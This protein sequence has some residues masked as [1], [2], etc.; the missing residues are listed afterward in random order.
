[1]SAA[2]KGP[3]GS[4]DLGS[5][6]VGVG[7][8]PANQLIVNDTEVS[9]LHAQI[10]PQGQGHIVIDLGSSNGT[11]VNGQRL[12]P[13]TPHRLNAGDTVRFGD[14]VFSYIIGTSPH[15][16][17]KVVPP[18]SKPNIEGIQPQQTPVNP[19]PPKKETPGWIILVGGL[20]SLATIFGVIWGVYTYVH[21]GGPSIPRLHASYIGSFTQVGA[22]GQLSLT[23]SSLTEDANGNFT[24]TGID[25]V[26]QATYQ[27]VVKTDESINF[28]LTETA[29]GTC[30]GFVS[31]FFG[32]VFL[33][34]HLAGSWQGEGA[35]SQ[36]SGT[37]TL[38]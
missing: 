22:S 17:T 29:K 23:I 15:P 12:P 3:Q 36:A 35:F 9:W 26:C 10:C 13:R 32:K 6:I 30:V 33:D 18:F 34:G 25:G 19:D 2:L 1:M 37:W 21:P 28:T 7:R 11:F 38:S 20:A 24:A 4:I 16:P 31:S 5:S 27:G 8:S 14:I